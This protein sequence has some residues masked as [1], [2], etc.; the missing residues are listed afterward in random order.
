MDRGSHVRA[1]GA[2][3]GSVVAVVAAVAFIVLAFVLYQ[4]GAGPSGSAIGSPGPTLRGLPTLE[5]HPTAV[6]PTVPTDSPASTT[7]PLSVAVCGIDQL[8]LAAGGWSGAT[9]SMA[10][11]ATLL[12][13]SSETCRVSGKPSLEL[14]DRAGKVI[15]EGQ[16]ASAEQPVAI[17]PGGV[18]TVIAVWSNWCTDPPA[19]PLTL[20]LSLAETKGTLRAAVVDWN[21]IGG[22]ESSSLPRCDAEGA[23]SSIAAPTPFAAPERPEPESDDAACAAE[24]LAAFLGSWGAAAG[25][26]Y[27]SVVLFNQGGV[28]CLVDGSPPLE[29]RDAAGEVVARGERSKDAPA[30]DLPAGLAASTFIGFADWCLRPPKLPFAWELRIGGERLPIALTS[31]RS[32]IGVPAC[33]S[34]PA[35]TSPDLFFSDP[36]ALPDG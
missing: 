4:G 27:A 25:T 2:A 24:D 31:K 16:P 35:S 21:A 26:S 11:G 12:N 1:S 23:G 34:D 15:A 19:R 10:G 18:A 28:G 36:F 5:A 14:L 20:T 6:P 17:L 9:G 8:A 7:D 3:R 30:V 22:E 29:L 13:V 32:V 33:Q